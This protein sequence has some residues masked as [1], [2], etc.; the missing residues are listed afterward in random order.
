MCVPEEGR[1]WGAGG[2]WLICSPPPTIPQQVRSSGLGGG[3]WAS[4]L[5]C[6]C[7]NNRGQKQEPQQKLGV[8]GV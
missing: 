4:L 5:A 7:D 8:R 1:G 6:G 3:G 2:I